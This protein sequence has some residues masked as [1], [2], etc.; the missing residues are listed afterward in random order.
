MMPLSFVHYYRT[1]LG[2][3][4]AWTSSGTTGI[5]SLGLAQGHLMSPA[6]AQLPVKVEKGGARAPKDVG[7]EVGVLLG[8]PLKRALLPTGEQY[9][10]GRAVASGSGLPRA[11]V[12]I[13]PMISMHPMAIHPSRAYPSVCL[14]HALP[15]ENLKTAMKLSVSPFHYYLVQATSHSRNDTILHPPGA[16]APSS[17]GL[18][19]GSRDIPFG[20]L[21][22]HSPAI[23]YGRKRN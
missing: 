1:C 21:C 14:R 4:L 12:S 16:G 13:H 3:G 9:Q 23:I 2:A 6:G 20:A 7:T 15:I 17:P 10:V 5:W 11:W 22:F 18:F 8:F 19:T